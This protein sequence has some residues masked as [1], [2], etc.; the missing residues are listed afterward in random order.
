MYCIGWLPFIGGW[1]WVLYEETK[2]LTLS[3]RYWEPLI[4]P[5]LNEMPLRWVQ[6]LYGMGIWNPPLRQLALNSALDI[7]KQSLLTSFSWGE[8]IH[9]L[10]MNILSLF[11]PRVVMIFILSL[12]LWI[13]DSTMRKWLVGFTWISMPSIAVTVLPQGRES[14]FPV[15]YVL[16]MWISIW[17]WIG[18][19]TGLIIVRLEGL[20]KRLILLFGLIGITQLP[21]SIERPSNIELTTAGLTVQ[22]WLRSY[23]PSNSIVLSSFET[24]PIVWLSERE[25]QE[26]PSPWESNKRIPELQESKRPVYGVVWAFDHHAWYSLSFEEKYYEP[27]AYFHNEQHAYLIFDLSAETAK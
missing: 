5:L 8:W 6:E 21:T 16:P 25:W 27:E 17:T 9:W 24:A 18:L 2:R 15:A 7:E 3:P 10:D 1:S 20:W 22:H 11:D 4:L 19:S 23:T 12:L 14:I 13:T 26:W